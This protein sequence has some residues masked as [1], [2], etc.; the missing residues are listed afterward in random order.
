MIWQ[1]DVQHFIELAEAQRVLGR[2]RGHT[3]RFTS[4]GK[5]VLA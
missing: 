1:C 2:A 5:Q 3:G 4:L